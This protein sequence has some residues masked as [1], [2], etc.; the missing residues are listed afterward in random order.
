MKVLV[1]GA[2]GLL[3][4]NLVRALIA[5]GH[6][7]RALVRATADL[8]GLRGVAVEFVQGDVRDAAALQKAAEGCQWLFHGAAVFSYWGY[9]RGEMYETAR[10]GAKNAVDAAK[11]AGVT[12]LLVTSSTSTLG[13]DTSRRLRGEEHA[14]D[15]SSFPDYF[16]TKALQER[17]VLQR[18]QEIG[19]DAVV[20]MPSLFVGPHDYKP[21]ASTPS[22]LAYITAPMSITFGGGFN[23]IH[24]ADVARGHI[25]I[26]ERGESHQRYVLADDNVTW[27]QFHEM[28]SQLC[29]LPPPRWSMSPAVAWMGAALMELGA[30]LTKRPPLA[31]RELTKQSR[32]Y[33]WN[34]AGKARALGF[35]PRGMRANLIDTLGWLL[36]SEHLSAKQKRR[37]APVEE[38]LAASAA[39]AE[40]AAAP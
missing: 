31:T 36:Q 7:V 3:G 40:A 13:A 27:T 21:S 15:L 29:G 24:A 4:S 35:S 25:L 38:V 10:E 34:D 16:Q 19:L 26:M 18:A 8:R 37:L 28:L 11:A 23:L 20:A 33:F 22:I 1:T 39:Y 5:D 17:T 2:N 14:P 32:N 6:D 12:R 9:S 30:S